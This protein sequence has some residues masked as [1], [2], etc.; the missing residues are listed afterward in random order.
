VGFDPSR[1]GI[2]RLSG[3]AHA[4]S[5][6]KLMVYG[7]IAI[8]YGVLEAVEGYGLFRRKRWGEYLTIIA[9]SL[10]FIP[11]I[12]ELTKKPTPLKIVALII[13]V[14]IVA[15]LAYRLRRRGG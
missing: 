2:Q 12:S 15:Y 10:L 9:T 1:N 13:N 7:L 4:L 14:V 6:R 8:S 11:E 3:E 5:P